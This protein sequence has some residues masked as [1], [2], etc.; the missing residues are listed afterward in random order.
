RVG[1]LL[2]MRLHLLLVAQASAA[3]AGLSLHD[4][5]PIWGRRP[6]PLALALLR[7]QPLRKVHPLFQLVHPL[8]QFIELAMAVL[9]RVR[10][11]G[12]RDRKSTRL[13]SSHGS[14][15]YA[16]F[17]LRKNHQLISREVL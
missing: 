11:T 2:L 13:N 12:L 16:V 6:Q 5:L 15:S 17:C 7:E 9:G 10:D 1:V 4:A 8:F 3:G 14:I